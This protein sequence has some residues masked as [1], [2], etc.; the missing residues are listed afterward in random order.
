MNLNE[1]QPISVH[2][3]PNSL[4]QLLVCQIEFI[5]DP[6]WTDLECSLLKPPSIHQ[7]L[8]N[9]GICCMQN[10][11]LLTKSQSE[12]EQNSILDLNISNFANRRLDM[13]RRSCYIKFSSIVPIKAFLHHLSC[14][15][16]SRV[17][18]CRWIRHFSVLKTWK[19]V[20]LLR[21]CQV[22][23]K[24]IFWEPFFGMA[25]ID[26]WSWMSSLV[27]SFCFHQRRPRSIA[28]PTACTFWYCLSRCE[29]NAR[30]VIKQVRS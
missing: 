23:L 20:I 11:Q 9:F 10:N 29:T 19:I 1:E 7:K 26:T 22:S 2:W 5:F 25:G 21:W 8:G 12:I 6:I 18:E 17:V 15:L 13:M 14:Q 30:L 28:T 27:S 3:G 16:F 4:Y 24:S